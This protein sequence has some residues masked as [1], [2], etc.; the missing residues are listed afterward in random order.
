MPRFT[1]PPAHEFFR[2][3]LLSFSSHQFMNSL[4]HPPLPDY[5]PKRFKQTSKGCS[6]DVTPPGITAKS[7]FSDFSQR[8]TC[9]I[10][11]ASKA[12][13][14]SILLRRLRPPVQQCQTFSI[15]IFMIS[16]SIQ[17]FSWRATTTPRL[18]WMF[19]MV[20]FLKMT[21]GFSL[22]PSPMHA[23]MTVR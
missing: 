10:L 22:E 6:T 8:F 1:D 11:C 19:G 20:L 9:S 13:N 23:K 2:W 16:L 4:S 5:V 14:T 21:S 15:Q 17:A 7:V 12:S 3:F 18:S